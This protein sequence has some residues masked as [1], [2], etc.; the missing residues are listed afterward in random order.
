MAETQGLRRVL[1][2]VAPALRAAHQEGSFRPSSYATPLTVASYA[3]TH[4]HLVVV[5]ATSSEAETL[6][7]GVRALWGERD[8]IALWPAWDTHPLERVSPDTSVMAERAL[9]AWRLASGD[10]PRVIIAPVRA[11]AQIGSP[12][13][14]TPLAMAR[15]GE[16][17]RE[18]FLRT[19][20]ELGYRR[21]HLVEHR[22][23]FAVRGGIVD[24]W[25]AQSNEPLRLDFFGD[26]I[27]RLTTFDIANQRSM[28]DV[29]RAIVAPAR[30]WIPS[31]TTR[32]RAEEMTKT[33]AWGRETFDRIA[34]GQLFDGMEGWMGLFADCL[35]YTSDAADE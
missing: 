19:L 14:A 6:L 35:L 1:E 2:L 10:I 30:E 17:D 16:Y 26:E 8:D 23:E 20:V 21:E 22:A 18:E 34:Q 9:L 12:A 24:V 32:Q 31:A 25:P 11:L 15:G 3:L 4:D 29:A 28:H 27:D 5:T 13:T 7:E 33:H